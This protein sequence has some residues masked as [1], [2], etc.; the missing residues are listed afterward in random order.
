MVTL[1]SRLR[2]AKD[3]LSHNLEGEAVLLSLHTGV[4]LGLDPVGTRI[5]NLIEQ[6]QSLQDVLDVLVMEYDVPRDR[7]ADDLL[8]LVREMQEHQLLEETA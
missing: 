8:S 3:I 4:Y 2:I 1:Q 7:C 5:W 6:Y